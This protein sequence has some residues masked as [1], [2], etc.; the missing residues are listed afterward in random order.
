MILRLVDD[1]YLFD[2]L[3]YYCGLFWAIWIVRLAVVE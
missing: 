1:G 3:G 2:C